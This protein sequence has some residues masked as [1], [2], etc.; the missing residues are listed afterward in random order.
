MM[1]RKS[2]LFPLFKKLERRTFRFG[3]SK[4]YDEK[5][6]SKLLKLY[7]KTVKRATDRYAR[8]NQKVC[9]NDKGLMKISRSERQ[10]NRRGTNSLK[11]QMKESKAHD[12]LELT[13]IY[14]L[15]IRTVGIYNEYSVHYICGKTFTIKTPSNTSENIHLEYNDCIKDILNKKYGQTLSSL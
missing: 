13:K 15:I 7:E 12:M 2:F 4:I 5:T 8:Y 9:S 14:G 1:N 10:T 11:I 6:R 3:K